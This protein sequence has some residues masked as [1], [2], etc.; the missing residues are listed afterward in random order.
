M[1]SRYRYYDNARVSA[2]G[3]PACLCR[4]SNPNILMVQSAKN[5]CRQNA[6]DHLNDPPVWRV[7]AADSDRLVI[8]CAWRNTRRPSAPAAPREGQDDCA[9]MSGNC[10]RPG[11]RIFTPMMTLVKRPW[12]AYWAQLCTIQFGQALLAIRLARRCKSPSAI[13]QIAALSMDHTPTAIIG[14]PHMT[15]PF[16][17][18]LRTNSPIIGRTPIVLQLALAISICPIV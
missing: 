5:W 4:K 18:P 15:M 8:K 9:R 12:W 1:L 17:S 11:S 16:R 6:S 13:A 3:R 14:C 10:T 7:L 2:P